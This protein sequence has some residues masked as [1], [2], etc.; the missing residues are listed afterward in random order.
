ML[1]GPRHRITLLRAPRHVGLSAAGHQPPMVS[2]DL[3]AG[4]NRQDCLESVVS[5]AAEPFG[6]EN[7]TLESTQDAYLLGDSCGGVIAMK[8]DHVG[9]FQERLR[10]GVLEIDPAPTVSGWSGLASR[11]QRNAAVTSGRLFSPNPDCPG[12]L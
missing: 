6:A 12:S 8:R 2:T 5:T 11:A 9:H 1:P 7:G 3:L 10:H 4:K